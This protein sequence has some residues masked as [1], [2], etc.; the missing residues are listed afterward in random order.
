M[1]ASLT[2]TLTTLLQALI[3]QKQ[4]LMGGGANGAAAGAATVGGGPGAAF[5]DPGFSSG[6]DDGLR[7]FHVENSPFGDGTAVSGPV[8]GTIAGGGPAPASSG[9]FAPTAAPTIN[10][11]HILGTPTPGGVI[12]TV[13]RS[14]TPMAAME[15]SEGEWITITDGAAQMHVH[16]H[17][18][19]VQHP[20]LIQGAIQ[21]GKVQVHLHP[22]GTA[23][24]HD[25]MA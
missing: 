3:A 13:I 16:A 18:I 6:G 4:L 7:G 11:Q 5:V 1:I 12:D 9:P 25:V 19:Y 21:S 10:Q 14:A 24:L 2:A 22:D 8:A 17:G 15:M 23:H 20:E